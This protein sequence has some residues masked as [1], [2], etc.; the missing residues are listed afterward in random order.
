MTQSHDDD[1]RRNVTLRLLACLILLFGVTSASASEAQPVNFTIPLNAPYFAN[2][3]LKAVWE[4]QRNPAKGRAAMMAA[5]IKSKAAAKAAVLGDGIG[6]NTKATV[7]AEIE[8]YLTDFVRDQPAAGQQVAELLRPGTELHKALRPSTAVQKTLD[9]MTEVSKSTV[10]PAAPPVTSPALDVLATVPLPRLR[11]A[12]G[13]TALNTLLPY[14][15][16]R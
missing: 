10:V 6:G 12:L 4:Y 11:E 8:K 9:R 13:R 16:A 7:S 3:M 14:P 15:L 2:L 5:V 1:R